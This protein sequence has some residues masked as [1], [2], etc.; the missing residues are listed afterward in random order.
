MH[1][2]HNHYYV[3]ENTDAA[4]AALKPIRSFGIGPAPEFRVPSL[5]NLPDVGQKEP[6]VDEGQVDNRTD[7]EDTQ[8]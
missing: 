6:Q 3:G 4:N 8:P 5:P 2:Q 1:E 7:D